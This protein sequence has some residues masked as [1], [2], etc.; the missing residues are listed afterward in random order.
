MMSTRKP[1][2]MYLFSSAEEYLLTGHFI[3]KKMAREFS[4]AV[5][6]IRLDNEFGIVFA[7]ALLRDFERSDYQT[8]VLSC[9]FNTTLKTPHHIHEDASME[10]TPD[11]EGPFRTYYD[12]SSVDRLGHAIAVCID[13]RDGLITT[14]CPKGYDLSDRNKS[15]LLRH[16]P[17]YDHVNI[18]ERQQYDEH[19]CMSYTIYNML[20]FAGVKS[21]YAPIDILDWR[22]EMLDTLEGI[23][24]SIKPKSMK[25]KALNAM[26]ERRNAGTAIYNQPYISI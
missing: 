2:P 10:L 23:E 26:H 11:R 22:G 17:D 8:L 6:S 24:K 21:L 14:R 25:M 5:N 1:N 4:I 12:G 16:L 9:C 7:G 20:A 15:L 18:R 3:P 19:S 13:K